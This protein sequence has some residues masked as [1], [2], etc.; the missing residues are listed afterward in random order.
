MIIGGILI[1]LSLALSLTI[2]FTVGF[3]IGYET[4]QNEKAN[5]AHVEGGT[6]T[7]MEQDNPWSNSLNNTRF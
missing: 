3:G 2:G 6:S 1:I 7:A 4:S 5:N